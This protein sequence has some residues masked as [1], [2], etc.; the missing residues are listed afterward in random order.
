MNARLLIRSHRQRAPRGWA[1][2]RGR[3]RARFQDLPS[4]A[5]HPRAVSNGGPFCLGHS[6]LRLV[7]TRSI[8]GSR[9]GDFAWRRV[10][11]LYHIQALPG[12]PRWSI[13]G[14]ILFLGR[15]SRSGRLDAQSRAGRAD[16]GA[17]IFPSQRHTSLI[18][19]KFDS[20]A[21]S[22]E[23]SSPPSARYRRIDDLPGIFFRILETRKGAADLILGLEQDV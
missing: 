15:Y 16:L 22:D 2:G 1:K 13:S 6:L 20:G 19:G 23:D 4:A 17:G 11:L 10:A 9:Q 8:A 14:A 18:C 7:L 3:E 21:V 5:R 12:R